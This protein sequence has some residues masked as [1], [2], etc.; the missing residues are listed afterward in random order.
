MEK[1]VSYRRPD[2]IERKANEVL[3]K[4]KEKGFYNFDSAT[5]VDLIVEKILRLKIDFVNLNKDFKGVLGA[6]DL[7]NRMIWVDD[8]LN[9]TETGEFVH[10]AVCNFTIAHEIGHYQFHRDY[11]RESK[12]LA[13]FHDTNSPRTKAI[14]IQANMFAAFLLMPRD[15]MIKE[16]NDLISRNYPIDYAIY[17]MSR[18]FK[19]SKK[20]VLYR[21]KFAGL[22]NAIN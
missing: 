1:G 7:E 13:L 16:W 20:V 11:Y 8:S 19:V 10:E 15:L 2:I 14:E 12:N 22:L 5:P 6:L 21:L 17:G 9:H 3:L 4:A 18:F